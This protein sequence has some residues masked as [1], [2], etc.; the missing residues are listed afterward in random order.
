MRIVKYYY[1]MY[2]YEIANDE[3]VNH[4]NQMNWLKE[5]ECINKLI[6]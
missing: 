4:P 1:K 3:K 5:I 6:P 2:S